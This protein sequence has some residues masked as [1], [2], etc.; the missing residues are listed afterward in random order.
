VV[1]RTTSIRLEGGHE[2][3]SKDGGK[4]REEGQGLEGRSGGAGARAC[5]VG[6]VFGGDGR[7]V[8]TLVS[9]RLRG[10]DAALGRGV[11]GAR[12]LVSGALGEHVAEIHA[13]VVALS[14]RLLIAVGDGDDEVL[15]DNL[16]LK[17]AS[18]TRGGGK[19]E[20]K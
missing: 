17:G 9:E 3:G 12:D 4:S 15:K 7:D 10:W 16:G 11:I 20:K 2:E 14:E 8:G 18:E 5:T 13:A 19:S 6:R 1:H